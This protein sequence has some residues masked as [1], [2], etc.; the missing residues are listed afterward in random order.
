VTGKLIGRQREYDTILARLR[1]AGPSVV[2]IAGP[3]GSGRTTLLAHVADAA[4]MLGYRVIGGKAE[5]VVVDRTS[6]EGNVLRRLEGEADDIGADDSGDDLTILTKARQFLKRFDDRGKITELL[7]KTAP[8]AILVD[9][10]NPSEGFGDWIA[11][12]LLPTLRTEGQRVAVVVADTAE[13]LKA[14]TVIA[15]VAIVL[16]PLDADD[17]REQLVASATGLTPPLDADELE[18]LVEVARIRPVV[19]G[20]IGDV[21]AATVMWSRES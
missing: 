13:R 9:G 3:I 15:D 17:V 19:A 6:S 18:R 16:G 10:Y 4:E 5:P 20:A 7:G 2:T 8:L 12:V 1:G 11:E 14:L 21:L